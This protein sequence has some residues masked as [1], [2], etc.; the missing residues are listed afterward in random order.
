M[1]STTARHGSA[2]PSPQGPGAGAAGGAGLGRGTRAVLLA[3]LVAE[4]GIVVTGGLVRLTGSG[5][6]CP[7]WPQCAPGSYV[8]TVHQAEGYHKY[9]EFGNRTLTFLVLVLAVAALVAVWRLRGPD[10]APR[11][12]LRALAAVPVVG[13]LAQAVIGGITVLTQL[14]P[15]TVSVHF[16]VSM[17]LVAASTLLLLRAL[18]GDGPPRLLVHPAV[19]LLAVGLAAVTAL[20]LAVGTVVTG[21]GPHSGDA[22]EPARYALDPRTVSWL[23]A[24]LVLLLVGLL[25]GLLVALH[26]SPAPAVAKRRGWWV[27][28]VVVLQGLVGYV[29]YATALPVPL[30]ALHMLGA[31]L[32]VVAVTALWTSLRERTGAAPARSASA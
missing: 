14:S 5:L 21:A 13:V 16:L 6:G 20:V 3:N 19:R 26:V 23:H 25:V 15:F 17:V 4:V 22:E 1:T 29:Q 12:R 10:G 27:L 28:G 8:P 18:E 11:R 24:D 32:L 7:T 30:V 31:C 2:T 9:I